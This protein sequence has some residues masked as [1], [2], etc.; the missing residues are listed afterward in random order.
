MGK[1]RAT[2]RQR[3]IKAGRGPSMNSRDKHTL[4]HLPLSLS[5]HTAPPAG[6][7]TRICDTPSC[8]F[9]LFQADN[10]DDI[11]PSIRLG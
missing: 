2:A 3:T 1:G 7:C 6:S 8:A 4:F 5:P 11:L 10:S 9:F